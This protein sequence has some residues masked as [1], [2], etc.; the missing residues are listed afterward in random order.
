M[1]LSNIRFTGPPVR[2]S[3]RQ[4]RHW[5]RQSLRPL[6]PIRTPPLN[7][8]L[9][10]RRI[11]TDGSTTTGSVK[12]KD[13][14]L[15]VSR[16]EPLRLPKAGR[17]TRVLQG[18]DDVDDA[19]VN[20][21]RPDTAYGGGLS[22]PV[23]TN[24]DNGVSRALLKFDTSQIPDGATVT[25][26]DMTLWGESYLDWGGPSGTYELHKLTRDFDEPTVTWNNANSTTPA[27]WRFA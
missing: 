14:G 16:P 5:S 21:N 12:T 19:E 7:S 15:S 6:P 4:Q 8:H 18:G 9:R 10:T 17:I 27:T 13:G 20:Q 11:R 22:M 24:L 25:D 3:L 1:T 26:A 2:R 23:G